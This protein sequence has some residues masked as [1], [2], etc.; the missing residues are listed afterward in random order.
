MKPENK[1]QQFMADLEDKDDRVRE[2][3]G[4]AL[5]ELRRDDKGCKKEK[6]FIEIARN[7]KDHITRWA[8]V[9][10]VNDPDVLEDIKT[11]DETAL[12]RRAAS[13]QLVTALQK[14]VAKL[15][16][17]NRKQAKKIE[18]Q[19]RELEL[20]ND[21]SPLLSRDQAFLIDLKNQIRELTKERD[22]ALSKRDEEEQK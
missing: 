5:E 3:A 21:R 22:D 19:R 9:H 15:R 18:N 7:D 16:E 20:F 13:V 12:V 6:D 10:E 11:R 4:G 1:N 2:F 17:I 14:L 8:A